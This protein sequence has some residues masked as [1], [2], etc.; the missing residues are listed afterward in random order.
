MSTSARRGLDGD[1]PAA[2]PARRAELPDPFQ[3]PARSASKNLERQPAPAAA[4][5][6][7]P[8]PVPPAVPRRSLDATPRSPQRESSIITSAPELGIDAARPDPARTATAPRPAAG[9]RPRVPAAEPPRPPAG[10]DPGP[11]PRAPMSSVSGETGLLARTR[12][13]R[14]KS[15]GFYSNMAPAY[16]SQTVSAPLAQSSLKRTTV[17]VAPPPAPAPS[18][19]GVV[20]AAVEPAAAAAPSPAALNGSERAARLPPD[21]ADP[22]AAPAANDLAPNAF[23]ASDL[24]ANDLAADDLAADDLTASA[25][26]GAPAHDLADED[27]F[28]KEET[29]PGVGHALSRHDPALRNEISERDLEL[30]V[31]FGMDLALGIAG[32]AWLTVARET[33][34]RLKLTAIRLSRGPLDKALAQLGVELEGASVLSEERR[35]RILQQLILVDLALPRPIDLAGERQRRERLI[36]QHLFTELSATHP[37]VAQRLRDDGS[38]SL[39]RFSQLDPAELGARVGL[40]R[41]QIEAALGAFRDYLDERAR[42]GPETALLG[43]GR[44]LAQRLAELEASAE[45][46]ERVAETEDAQAKREA[47][48]RRQSDIARVSLFL[49]EWGE[50]GILAEFERSSVQGK[51]ARLRRWMME[52]PAS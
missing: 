42:R 47:R 18:A 39:E 16:G 43:K 24:A 11:P 23:A 4:P 21:A 6:A 30:L 40:D 51:I 27:E 49:A 26:E 48:R 10:A 25:I 22:L 19:Q 12:K 14:T 20:K 9:V 36:V 41:E 32:E 52:L 2:P 7:E 37:L 31:Q 35:G 15:P 33:T 5:P 44:L 13:D 28:E 46:F 38:V 45:Y 34:I 29:A 17:G 8:V 1:V 50:A 3:A